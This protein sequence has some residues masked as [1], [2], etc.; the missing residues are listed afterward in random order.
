MKN[1]TLSLVLLSSSLCCMDQGMELAQRIMAEYKYS[2]QITVP[3]NVQHRQEAIHS[4]T[5]RKLQLVEKLDQ[6][7]GYRSSGTKNLLLASATLNLFLLTDNTLNVNLMSFAN[8]T[9]NLV[10]QGIRTGLLFGAF[11]G[12]ICGSLDYYYYYTSQSEHTLKNDIEC[13]KNVLRS[14]EN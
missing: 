14:L 8:I 2:G 12:L 5:V 10:N 4:L 7:K 9:D 11:K 6:L 13:H 3:G 1:I